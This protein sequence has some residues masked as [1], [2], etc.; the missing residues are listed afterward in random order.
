MY[1]KRI[2]LVFVV[3][4]FIS[5]DTDDTSL[6]TN[7]TSDTSQL[8]PNFQFIELGQG[9]LFLNSREALFNS[10]SQSFNFNELVDNSGGFS[11]RFLLF[12]DYYMSFDFVEEGEDLPVF[13]RRQYGSEGDVYILPATE[14]PTNGIVVVNNR[15]II[16][17]VLREDNFSFDLNV[18][19]YI[20][21]ETSIIESTLNLS[22]SGGT[23]F[24]V[25]NN[26]YLIIF[27]QT[28]DF[29]TL[30]RIYDL[31]SL[32]ESASLIIDD[33]INTSSGGPVI[34]E[35]IGDKLF[36]T[37][38]GT[39]D[40]LYEFN[41]SSG[42][43]NGSQSYSVFQ[44]ERSVQANGRIY[45]GTKNANNELFFDLST[46]NVSN[47]TMSSLDISELIIDRANDNGYFT[48]RPYRFTYSDEQN[49][50]IVAVLNFDDSNLDT[51]DI[52]YLK[53]SNEGEIVASTETPEDNE[54]RP[55]SNL[56]AD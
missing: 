52:E 6:D 4:I 14:N 15:Q 19:N 21:G 48:S 5:C 44:N 41:L 8:F 27:N 10:D 36:L 24:K 13:I 23:Q 26:D 37:G 3:L 30:V 20:T 39:T 38:S 43:Y 35:I 46:I 47:R 9:S 25:F 28:D 42:V 40:T 55:I 7:A 50:W 12:G 33:L 1:L 49:V 34:Q 31:N 22:T 45:L 29:K 2:I 51:A 16:R 18:Y 11:D 53:I 54:T 17:S 32:T 56:R